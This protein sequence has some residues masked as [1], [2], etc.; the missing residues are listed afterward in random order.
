M[1]KRDIFVQFTV[2]ERNLGSSRKMM[3]FYRLFFGF[4]LVRVYQ[5]KHVKN[6]W[7]L[8]RCPWNITKVNTDSE[9][10]GT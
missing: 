8:L 2:G 1:Q 6:S 7:R 10:R 9:K 5:W 3:T 4:V